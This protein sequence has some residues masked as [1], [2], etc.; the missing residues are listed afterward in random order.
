MQPVILSILLLWP[1]GLKRQGK[2]R[3]IRQAGKPGQTPEIQALE[4]TPWNTA[5]Q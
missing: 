1:K 2:F 4:I 3:T 5:G